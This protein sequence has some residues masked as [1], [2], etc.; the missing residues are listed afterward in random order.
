M[1]LTLALVI[2]ETSGEIDHIIKIYFLDF[3]LDKESC[4]CL[5]MGGG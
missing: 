5:D 3:G 2:K 1:C 4:K